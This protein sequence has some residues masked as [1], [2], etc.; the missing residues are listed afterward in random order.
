MTRAVR[1]WHRRPISSSGQELAEVGHPKHCP[2][3]P[4]KKAI[5]G[6]YSWEA[7]VAATI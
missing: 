7:Y 4:A 2:A 5:V 1:S 6:A 3:G